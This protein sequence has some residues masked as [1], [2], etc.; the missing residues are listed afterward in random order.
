MRHLV[1]VEDGLTNV[2]Q[3][4][5]QN[6]FKAVDLSQNI[7]NPVAIIVTG[8]DENFLGME[9]VTNEVPVINCTSMTAE[10]VVTEVQRRIVH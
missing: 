9:T 5:E 1:A 3:A 4:L 7:A 6:G 8:M 2:K 10:Q